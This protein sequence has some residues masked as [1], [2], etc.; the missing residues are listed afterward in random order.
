VLGS[1]LF[2]ER[3]KGKQMEEVILPNNGLYSRKSKVSD[4]IWK[5]E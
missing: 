1:D 2:H 3:E 5:V 4:S